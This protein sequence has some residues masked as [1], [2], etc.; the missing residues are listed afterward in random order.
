MITPATD[1]CGD[2]SQ[3]N[4]S[5]N[6]SGSIPSGDKIRHP[7]QHYFPSHMRSFNNPLN[8]P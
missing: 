6:C 4:Q 7:E 5:G 2:A 3:S 8:F 1:R